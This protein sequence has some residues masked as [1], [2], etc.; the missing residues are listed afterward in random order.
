MLSCRA[1]CCPAL[2]WRL[3]KTATEPTVNDECRILP[4]KLIPLFPWSLSQNN[5]EQS[6]RYVDHVLFAVAAAAAAARAAL[7]P[8]KA[9]SSGRGVAVIVV[10]FDASTEAVRAKPNLVVVR[11]RHSK[12]ALHGQKSIRRPTT[13]RQTSHFTSGSSMNSASRS[14]V[15]MHERRN[16]SVY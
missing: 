5:D 10:D 16:P 6:K 11:G 15:N 1:T 12:Y 2:D 7:K 13:K 4:F 3:P 9:A 8:T 14:L